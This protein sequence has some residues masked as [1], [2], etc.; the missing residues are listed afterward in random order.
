M[1]TLTLPSGI[2]LQALPNDRTERVIASGTRREGDF[3]RTT[4]IAWW[5]HPNCVRE[6]D[7]KNWEIYP[8]DQ[9]PARM[10][11]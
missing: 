6:F 7:G 11:A 1:K 5:D 10:A 3:P 2:V 8:T 4:F 9:A